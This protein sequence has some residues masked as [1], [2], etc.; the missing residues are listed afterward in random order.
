MF[1]TSPQVP[2]TFHNGIVGTF[3][4]LKTHNKYFRDVDYN[5]NEA[6]QWDV[7]TGVFTGTGGEYLPQGTPNFLTGIHT[8]SQLYIASHCPSNHSSHSTILKSATL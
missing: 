3:M 6:A 5:L 7:R 2:R 4:N 8:H 1:L